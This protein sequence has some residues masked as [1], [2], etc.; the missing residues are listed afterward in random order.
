LKSED[1]Q[2]FLSKQNA[3]NTNSNISLGT[4]TTSKQDAIK[5]LPYGTAMGETGKL[6]FQGISGNSVSLRAPSNVPV[7]TTWVLPAQDGT[8]GQ[9]LTTNGTGTLGW[10]E[11]IPADKQA[12]TY[13]KVTTNTLGQVVSGGNLTAADVPNLDASKITTGHLLLPGDPTAQ[14]Q[15]VPK[16]YV[17]AIRNSLASD[18]KA[19]FTGR[20]PI[21]YNFTTGEIGIKGL[22]NF[23]GADRILGVNSAGSALEYK[24]FFGTEKQIAVSNSGSSVTFALPQNISSDSTPIFLGLTL[25][26]LTQGPVRSN[27]SGVLTSTS[28]DLSTADVIGTLPIAKGG[29][30]QGATPSLGEFLAG[31]SSGAFTP[32]RIVPGP[33]GSV[34][35]SSNP[36]TITIDTVQDL[37]TSAT[38]SFSGITLASGGVTTP[39]L[40]VSTITGP[41]ASSANTAGMS[42]EFSGGIGLGTGTSGSILFKTGGEGATS[43]TTPT[44]LTTRMTITPSGQIGIATTSPSASLDISTGGSSSIGLVIRPIDGTQTG[45]LTQWK[46]SSGANLTTIDK[47]GYLTLPGSPT[48]DLH[49]ATKKYVDDEIDKVDT[50]LDTLDTTKVPEGTNLYFTSD[51]ARN[52]ITATPPLEYSSSNG[53]M[54]LK[55]LTTFG[56]SNQLMGVSAA[57]GGLEYK[58][59]TGTSNQ[60]SVTHTPGGIALSTPQNIG[61]TSN[62]TFA[63][64]SLTGPTVGVMKIGLGGTISTSKVDLATTGSTEEVTGTLPIAKGGTGIISAP[65]SG[66]IL[67][68]NNSSG[69]SLGH[70][71][72][73][74]GVVVT[75]GSGSVSISTV[76]KIGQGDSPTFLGL[77]VGADGLTSSTKLSTPLITLGSGHQTATPLAGLISG[78]TASGTDKMGASINIAAGNGTGIG[79]SGDINFQTAAPA[80][81]SGNTA[82][83]M[84]TRMSILKDGSVRI[85]AAGTSGTLAVTT[86]TDSTSGL[87][88][89][90]NSANQTADLAQF[91]AASGAIQSRI[92]KNGFFYQPADPTENLQSATK[93]YVDWAVGNVNQNVID[94]QNSALNNGGTS[95]QFWRGDK[96]WAAVNTDIINEGTNNLFFTQNRARSSISSIAPVV[97]ESSTGV[98]SLSGLTD[99]GASNQI[100]AMNNSGNSLEYKTIEGTANQ[101]T[102][103]LNTT[104]GKIKFATPQNIASTDSPTFNGLTL[105][106]LAGSGIVK[107]NGAGVLSSAALDLNNDTAAGALAINKGGTGQISTP[108]QGQILV[109]TSTGGFVPANIS[110]GSSQG[111]TI[112]NGSGSIVLDTAQDIR[113]SASPSFTGVTIASGGVKSTFIE[114]PSVKGTSVS[115]TDATGTTLNI[116]G[117]PGTG[118]GNS[119]SIYFRT[120]LGS[121]TSGS[122]VNGLASRMIITPAGNVGVSTS[123]PEARL[124]IN[125]GADNVPGLIV[126]STNGTQSADLTQWL[127]SAGS[128]LSRIDKDGY[129]SLP[130]NPTS[131]LQAA[132]KQYVDSQVSSATTSIAGLTTNDVPE[133]GRQYFTTARA[134]GAISAT[135]PLSYN[136]GV[137]GIQG[138]SSLGTANQILGMNAAANGM[139]FKSLSGSTNILLTQSAGGV[140]I[141]TA[142]GIKTTDSPVFTGL[143]VSG[144]PSGVMKSDATGIVSSSAVDL[145]S[146]DAAGILP[147]SKGGTGLSA[148]PTDGQIL[149]GNG[150]TNS[151]NRTTLTPGVGISV[152]NSA[153]AITLDT[154][155]DIRTTAKPTFD[156]LTIGSSGMV[157]PSIIAGTGDGTSTATNGTIR[158]AKI[159]GTNVQGK[160]LTI[161][162]GLGTGDQTSGKIIFRT[163]PAG[164]SGTGQNI[165]A[166]RA[167]IDSA[168]NVGIG[169]LTP[170]ALFSIAGTTTTQTKISSSGST[171]EVVTNGNSGGVLRNLMGDQSIVNADPTGALK[172]STNS[173]EKMRLTSD[174]KLGIGT[175]SPGSRTQVMTGSDNVVGMQVQSTNST[176]VAD[177][178]QWLKSDGT[179]LTKIDKDGF[180]TLPGSP[181]SANHAATKSY[182]DSQ[183]G[184]TNTAVTGK[185][186][187]ITPGTTDQYWRGDKTWQTLD[188]SAVPEPAN[189]TNLY[190]TAARAKSAL[191]A[192]APIDYSITS[193]AISLQNSGVTAGTYTRATLTVDTFGRITYATNGIAISS[194]DIQ[195]GTIADGDISGSAAISDGKLAT[196]TSGGKVAN[197]ATTA[198]SASTANTIVLRDGSGNFAAGAG[199]FSSLVSSGNVGIGTTAPASGLDIQTGTNGSGQIRI[200]ASGQAGKI[201]F[202]RGDGNYYA[203]AGFPTPSAAN[204]FRFHNS[205]GGGFFTF[206]N[207]ILGAGVAE[208]FRIANNGN[209]GIGS[210]SPGARLDVSGGG[211]FTGQIGLE[212]VPYGSTAGN[213][214]ELRF[215]ELAANGANFV[216]FKA[217]DHLLSNVIWTLPSYDGLAGNVLS[218]NG[219]G[220]LS[221]IPSTTGSVTIVATGTGLSGGPITSTGTISLANVGTAGTY[222][223]V[224]TNAQGQVTTGSSLDATDIPALDASKI[225]TGTLSVALGGTGATSF[226][227]NGVLVGSGSSPL[228]ATVAGT[229]YQVL[230][231]G[232]SGVP[233]FGSINLDQAAAVTGAL[234]LGNG[235]TG[236]TTA[237]AARTNLGLGTAATLNVGTAAS[238]IIQLDGSGKLPVVDGTQ[239]T[240]VVKTAGDTMTGLLNL[241]SNG[242]VVGTNQL[243]VSGSHVGIGTTAPNSKLDVTSGV[244]GGVA[245]VLK[246]R[247][248][249]NVANSQAQID[250]VFGGASASETRGAISGLVKSSGDGN[251]LFK[252]FESVSGLT[253]RMRIDENGNVGI[254]TTAPAAL[255][256]LRGSGG[257][258]ST[259]NALRLDNPGAGITEGTTNGLLFYWNAMEAAKVAS[260]LEAAG[261]PWPTSL[262]FYTAPN[263]SGA[264]EKMRINSAGNVGIGT[265]STNAKLTVAGNI[266]MGNENLVCNATTEG[267]QRYNSISKRMEICNGSDWIKIKVSGGTRY[268]N[269]TTSSYTGTQIASWTN[270]K[271]LCETAC[272]DTSA[273][274]CSFS[275][276]SQVL[277]RGGSVPA[278]D[279][280]VVG[281][282][283]DNAGYWNNCQGWTSNSH[284]GMKYSSSNVDFVVA[285]CSNSMPLACCTE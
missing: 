113:T 44:P 19:A 106:S 210:S 40:N 137:V 84:S 68:G 120:G 98:L 24:T 22:S 220:A 4:L 62:P 171:A 143:R 125:T 5:I 3:I 80:A 264:T 182:V 168:G 234:G 179:I 208:T 165:P 285:V 31:N 85:G 33:L 94:L 172:F 34:T 135:A 250:F 48:V 245:N 128:I 152:I 114:S 270:A 78:A 205:S 11:A 177:L 116:D 53:L 50:S 142:Q 207:N 232:A 191:Q 103:D 126:R 104:P 197:S 56:T 112:T 74:D 1:F 192:V 169:T 87:V 82:N 180:I 164:S 123:A 254:G 218:T 111:V 283:G 239:V 194:S 282:G 178:M 216:G 26:G 15:A 163:A 176:Q 64:L 127:G 225:T 151:Y 217:P 69:Y 43:G 35:T 238:N 144:L 267:S 95:N 186:P 255:L 243:V 206:E 140:A 202:S 256:H 258:S 12:G 237:A 160:D 274:M 21:D 155:Q 47:N 247:N 60:I 88:I 99:L 159:S 115:G 130:G 187:T 145:A 55:G 277:Q 39:S 271:S 166:T 278:V 257:N 224:T 61:I 89:R 266:Q 36:G 96:T 154:V 280:W 13:T 268:C 8:P 49:A 81:S 223:K 9:V 248:S 38:P 184:S 199:T 117:G 91:T 75:N 141:D 27:A 107:T 131:N 156:G 37:R 273:F 42:L 167:V 251:L 240:G 244:S 28:I 214:S 222:S 2:T 23:G 157:S 262:A 134:Q 203:Y 58:S 219:S 253:E 118:T 7:N 139:E 174:G 230:R 25:S 52:A 18:A 195:D 121:L 265:T 236:A 188:T 198:T 90:P 211:R 72:A 196:I 14:L 190:F 59:I 119:G 170:D 76:Q 231:A 16:Q 110:Q 63:G 67:I 175:T 86:L 10:T 221:W 241:P 193:G 284:W 54:T 189:A 275:D 269:K 276:I 32:T 133:G 124:Q 129:L 138:L 162:A 132:T 6:V 200:G 235:G 57:G 136:S 215:N 92:D 147:V 281:G 148:T 45:D 108:T 209:V 212:L 252:V 51:R 183:L 101:V 100:L 102:V 185:E 249:I 73:G 226:T 272:G 79:G 105:T 153:G 213:T 97:Y 70:L 17:D 149:I 66:Q 20:D 65:A 259:Y 161:E 279:T 150:T 261:N 83:G 228:S 109:G 46:N 227:N 158:A 229:E 260:V 71:N 201:Y 246:A 233:A 181:T 41:A 30:G 146:S 29:T 173:A 263:P 122:S 77:T 93:Q 242:L 204:E